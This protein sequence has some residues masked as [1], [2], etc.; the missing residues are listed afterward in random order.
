MAPQKV[1]VAQVIS[2]LQPLRL[3]YVE[4]R[5]G[6]IVFGGSVEKVSCEGTW[7]FVR[8]KPAYVFDG[9]HWIMLNYPCVVE[10][11]LSGVREISFNGSGI[12]Q[13]L[14]VISNS[15]N[16]FYIFKNLINRI[17]DSPIVY[18]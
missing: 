15:Y 8:I 17:P 4:A 7:V 18:K 9:G 3:S 5:Q 14:D 6:K 10:A 13:A 1:T 2:L 12:C 11:E 16:H